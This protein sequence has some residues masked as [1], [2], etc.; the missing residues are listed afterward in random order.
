MGRYFGGDYEGAAAFLRRAAELYPE[1]SD[2][3]YNYGW[4]LG[5]LHQMDAAIDELQSALA[6][7]SKLVPARR[8]LASIF[9]S[10]GQAELAAEQWKE[11]LAIDPNDVSSL[12]GYGI[13]LA[14]QRP[15]AEAIEY[16]RKAVQMDP[17]EPEVIDGYA[18][19]EYLSGNLAEAKRIILKGGDYYKGNRSFEQFRAAV[20]GVS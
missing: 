13:F 18:R 17:D 19:V 12:V 20:L 5:K 16:L 10:R 3:H 15:S 8:I 11:A 2:I 1:S 7:N 14:E 6:M 9:A 4:M